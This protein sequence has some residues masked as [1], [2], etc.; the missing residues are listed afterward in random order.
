MPSMSGPG[1]HYTWDGDR[2]AGAGSMEI[3]TD[4]PELVTIDLHFSRPFRARNRIE[5]ALTPSGAGAHVPW[6]LHGEL[7]GLVRVFALI[8]PMDSL[9]GPD[10]ERGL[11]RLKKVAE[12]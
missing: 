9:V 12:A 10:F 6:T 5:L 11:G 8:K 7:S 3:L 4:A 2:K 1:A